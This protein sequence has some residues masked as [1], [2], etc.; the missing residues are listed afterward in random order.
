MPFWYSWPSPNNALYS[1]MAM[2]YLIWETFQPPSC[3][4]LMKMYV[5]SRHYDQENLK[6]LHFCCWNAKNSFPPQWSMYRILLQIFKCSN[7]G[8]LQTSQ[9]THIEEKIEIKS[10]GEDKT[11]VVPLSELEEFHWESLWIDHLGPQILSTGWGIK[12]PKREAVMRNGEV[13]E[14][15]YGQRLGG[16]T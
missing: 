6:T 1:H 14:V 12:V 8:M 5:L 16:E 15:W 3:P 2:S 9:H 4:K 7:I 10:A 11:Q 13:L